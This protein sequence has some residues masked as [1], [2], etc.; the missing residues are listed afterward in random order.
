MRKIIHIAL[1]LFCANIFVAAQ[2]TDI[3][4]QTF[5]YA[6]KGEHTLKLDKYELASLRGVSKPCVIFVFGGGFSGGARDNDDNTEFMRSMAKKGY[7]GIAID[8]R[9]G[10]KK[11]RNSGSSEPAFYAGML[12]NSVN[13]AVEDLLSATSYVY[14]HSAEWNINREQ[15][16]ACGS[17]AGAITV[18][19]AEYVLCNL[20]S[21][22]EG[23]FPANFNYA[24][25]IAFAGSIFAQQDLTWNRRP[26]PIQMFHGDADRNVPFDHVEAVGWRIY[27]SKYIAETLS[28]LD[29]P[30]YFYEAENAG[31]EIAGDSMRDNIEEITAFMQRFVIDKQ[32]LTIHTKVRD[33]TK[34]DVRKDFTVEDYLRTNYQ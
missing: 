26:A 23:N 10:M 27:G 1:L 33:I 21:Q 8:Y 28:N 18:L 11:A 7:V 3:I 29:Y 20:P 14:Q 6:V 19:Q 22:T 5:T 4:K 12:V 31:H 17:S 34:P 16:V 13:M 2:N 30:Y 24:G 32:P 15:I 9:L 25:I